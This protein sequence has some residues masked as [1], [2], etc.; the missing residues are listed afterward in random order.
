MSKSTKL[1]GLTGPTG[2]G[3]TTVA[4]LFRKQ[5]IY[6]VDCDKV[7]REVIQVADRSKTAETVF[8]DRKKLEEFNKTNFPK[9][10]SAVDKLIEG[11]KIAV[12]DASQLFESGYD[13]KCDYIISVIANDDTRL[14]R[15]IKR[16]K[17]TKEQAVLRM[18]SQLSA[19]FFRKNSNL[20]IDN[21]TDNLGEN[22]IL[23]AE[24]ISKI[25]EN[26]K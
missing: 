26:V 7:A 6:V 3:K 8:S 22:D 15:I 20:V 4:D 16:D 24:D 14:S 23:S 9:I 18:K 1:I 11:Q 17:I 2:A 21:S 13:K 19:E 10:I 12:I 5:G 25:L